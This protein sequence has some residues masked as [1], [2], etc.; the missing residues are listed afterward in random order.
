MFK[1]KNLFFYSIIIIISFFSALIFSLIWFSVLH[2]EKNL[3]QQIIQNRILMAKSWFLNNIDQAKGILHYQYQPA[4]NS[5]SNKNNHTRQLAT[6]WA[7]TELNKFLNNDKALT[8]LINST[9]DYY[10]YFQKCPADYCYL[11]IE[12]NNQIAQNAF[13]LLALQN[14]P[15]YPNSQNLQ[16]KFA[17]AL[18]NQQRTDG[19]YKL[20]FDQQKLTGIN[21][22]PGEAMLA[23][24]KYYHLNNDPVYLA[25]V[26]KAHKY[27]Q[28]YWQ[29]N[30]NT[31]FIP[32][33]TQAAYYLYQE[34][35]NQAIADFIF[36]MNDW[37]IA[38]NQI[39][40]PVYL[41]GL[42]D[43]YKLA[44]QNQNQQRI[45][46]YKK[47]INLSLN[48]LLNLQYTE[49]SAQNLI[50]PQ[51]AIGGFRDSLEKNQQRID[52]TQHGLMALIKI[53][54]YNIFN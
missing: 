41:E 15:N 18:I 25:S 14:E 36:N 34:T 29:T 44:V 24:I 1:Y 40:T 49:K 46:E 54:N 37:L 31:A 52:S 7:I 28:K 6:L 3:N 16:K 23:L 45:N 53:Y 38:E 12:D 2:S 47:T 4:T 17:Q 32:W 5:Y 30:K 27:Y 39:I 51:K 26:Q 43:A 13:I 8:D 22:Y 9:F 50:N 19:S 11:Q 10:L 21:Y 35:E 48:H 33:Q 20:Y 42:I